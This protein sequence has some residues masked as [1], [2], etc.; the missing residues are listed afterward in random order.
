[1]SFV[2]DTQLFFQSYLQPASCLNIAFVGDETNES[3]VA[4]APATPTE[5]DLETTRV[6]KSFFFSLSPW[7]LKNTGVVL[8]HARR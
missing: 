4:A 8:F 3:R 5:Q 7:I 1:M 6:C 2:N